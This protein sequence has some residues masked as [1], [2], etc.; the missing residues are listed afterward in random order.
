MRE[1]S[2]AKE[3]NEIKDIKNL[4]RLKKALNYIVIKDIA[5]LFTYEKVAT[6]KYKT[7][8][9]NKNF[10]EHEEEKQNYFKP[11]R[12]SGFWSNNY[13]EYQRNGDRNKTLFVDEYLNKLRPYLKDIIDNLKQT[14][15]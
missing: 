15:K 6:I 9:G 4:F 1:S 11:V 13:I 12:V 8:R 2:R 14:D 7:L 10:C 3:K 5:N